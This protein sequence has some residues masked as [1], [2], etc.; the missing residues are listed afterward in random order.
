MQFIRIISIPKGNAPLSIRRQWL[1]LKLPLATASNP[2]SDKEDER[3]NEGEEYVVNADQA[4]SVLYKSS[5][6]TA[7]LLRRNLPP[8]PN[9]QIVFAKNI[10]ELISD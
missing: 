4:L 2:R 7:N 6:K 3:Q 9:N 1:G 10:C 8:V 5:P